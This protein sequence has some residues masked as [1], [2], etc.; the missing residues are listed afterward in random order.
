MLPN[1]PANATFIFKLIFFRRNIRKFW[2][3][4]QNKT[5]IT[6]FSTL[7]IIETLMGF[8]KTGKRLF[9]C[10][11]HLSIITLLLACFWLKYL[12]AG[13]CGTSYGVINQ[14]AQ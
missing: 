11:K 9:S 12:S 5:D 4:M 3:I 6:I 14:G 10:P 7:S 2:N 13:V 1:F 8:I